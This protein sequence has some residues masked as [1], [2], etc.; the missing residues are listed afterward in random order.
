[1]LESSLLVKPNGPAEIFGSTG[2]IRLLSPW[3]EKSAGIEVESNDGEIHKTSFDWAGH[4]LQFEIEEVVSCISKQ[5]IESDLMPHT[6]SKM[7]LEIMDKIRDQIHVSY[8]KYE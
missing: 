4:G 5:Q 2:V 6:L 8:P 3:F 1:M 7:I